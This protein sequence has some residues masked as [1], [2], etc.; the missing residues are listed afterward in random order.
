MHGRSRRPWRLASSLTTLAIA[1]AACGTTV[2]LAEQRQAQS[3]STGL[4]GESTSGQSTD[5]TTGAGLGSSGGSLGGSGD[6]T[7][8]SS[9]GGGTSSSTSSSGGSAGATSGLGGASAT[10]TGSAASH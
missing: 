6:A 9:S 8:G 5:A 3:G 1:T 7:A 2:P 4:A 10:S